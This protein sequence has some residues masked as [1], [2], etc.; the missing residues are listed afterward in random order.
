[1][2]FI[3]EDV[4]N[5]LEWTSIDLFPQADILVGKRIVD[6]EPINFNMTDELMI[7]LV[8]EQSGKY[9]ALSI[10]NTDACDCDPSIDYSDPY[11]PP[12]VIRMAEIKDRG[13]AP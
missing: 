5:T 9:Y 1:M 13:I 4:M 10:V 12:L 6:A 2:Y 8:D 11:L 7:Y 3:S